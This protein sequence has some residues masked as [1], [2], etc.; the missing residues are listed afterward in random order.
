MTGRKE[1]LRNQLITLKQR[2][3]KISIRYSILQ[4][5]EDRD[6]DEDENKNGKKGREL[7]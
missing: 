1:G 2:S 5:I 4:L 6:G 7:V 3:R